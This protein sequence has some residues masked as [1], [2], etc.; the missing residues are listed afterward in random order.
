MWD[1]SKENSG[2][3]GGGGREQGKYSRVATGDDDGVGALAS[4]VPNDALH[5]ADTTEVS[6]SG[7]E[8]GGE[9]RG[10]I[11]TLDVDLAGELALEVVGDGGADHGTLA[12]RDMY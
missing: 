8:V 2:V 4:D 6:T 5:L 11:D 12:E 1:G 7:K 10:V 3:G 9:E